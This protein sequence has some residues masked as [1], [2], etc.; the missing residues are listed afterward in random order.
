MTKV[1]AVPTKQYRREVRKLKFTA[2]WWRQHSLHWQGHE[3]GQLKQFIS[4]F[5]KNIIYLTAFIAYR[6]WHFHVTVACESSLR[7]VH[8]SL[9]VSC[10]NIRHAGY[11]DFE[12]CEERRVVSGVS[13]FENFPIAINIYGRAMLIIWKK[14]KRIIKNSHVGL[15]FF[16]L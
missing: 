13:K 7:W 6:A 10:T 3:P 14:V 2:R 11:S 15:S 1:T 16:I 4:N 9:D 5:C 8:E 12:A